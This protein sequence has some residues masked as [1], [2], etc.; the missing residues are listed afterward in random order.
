MNRWALDT[1]V[2]L[3]RGLN[4][5]PALAEDWRSPDGRTLV[6]A[7]RAGLRFADGRAVTAEDV[8]ESLAAAKRLSW[9]NVGYLAT[10]EGVRALDA[11]RIEVRAA[12]PDPTLLARL[13]WAFVLPADAVGKKPVPLTGTGP[14]VLEGWVRDESFVFARS[15]HHWGPPAPFAR[16]EFRVVPDDRTRVSLVERGEA[17]LADFVPPDTW[18]TFRNRAGLRLVVGAGHRVLFLGLRMDR[19]PFADPRVREALDLAIDR[20]LLRDRVLAGKGD[21]ANQ[22][23]PRGVVGFAPDLP[24]S[25]LDR[26]RARKLLKEAGLPPGHRLRLDGP[27]NRYVQDVALMQEVARQLAEVGL[28][29]EVQ[30]LEKR[31]LFRLLDEG[32]SLF[33]LLGWASESG[34]GADVFEVLFPFSGAVGPGHSNASGLA[35]A[36]LAALV[37]EAQSSPNLRQRAEVLR[38]AFRRVAELRPILPLVVQPEAVVYDPRRVAWDPPV[39]LALRP[40]DLRPAAE[41]SP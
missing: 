6:L 39:S 28:D 33:H 24:P 22:L 41:D 4:V 12:R 17:D 13:A 8:A 25:R 23:L 29:V 19:P 7:L 31:E 5:V 27:K 26:A 11:Q 36:R 18:E 34:D 40:H 35:D 14:Y 32:S 10:V 3:D 21:I 15:A 16:A 37:E 2:A 20:G 38:R 30:P 9:P 1:V